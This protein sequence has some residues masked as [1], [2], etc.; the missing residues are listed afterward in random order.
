MNSYGLVLLAAGPSSRMGEPKQL[1]TFEGETLLVRAL[2][3]GQEVVG[4]NL[5]VVLGANAEL[6][7]AAIDQ[8]GVQVQ[9]NSDWPEGIASS[10]RAGV[11]AMIR[12][13]PS[14]DGIILMVCDQPF[15]NP[16][17]LS[18]LIQANRSTSKPIVAC[19]YGGTVGTPALFGPP[20]FPQLQRLSGSEGARTIFREHPD[21]LTT[22]PFAQGSIDIDSM[23]DYLSLS[24]TFTRP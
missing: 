14:L 7:L 10:I 17:L 15:V 5:V 12:K 20:L 22:I 8:P 23:E 24:R 4:E 18:G 21:Q 11:A 13:Y 16:T 1:L 2:R 19:S 3:S 9:L 6:I